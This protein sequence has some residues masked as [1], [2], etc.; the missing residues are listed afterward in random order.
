MFA[1]G[2]ASNVVG[3]RRACARTHVICNVGAC[4]LA[5]GSSRP[6][7]EADADAARAPNMFTKSVE[8]SR[9]VAVSTPPSVI[10]TSANDCEGKC[11]QFGKRAEPEKGGG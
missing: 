8:A 6:R 3:G 5:E 4:Q 10:G 7:R 11:V 1:G 2:W 9:K